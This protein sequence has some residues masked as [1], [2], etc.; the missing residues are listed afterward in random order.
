MLQ[1]KSQT[2]NSNMIGRISFKP[3]DPPWMPPGQFSQPLIGLH[4]FGDWTLNVGWAMHENCYKLSNLSCQQPP[5]GNWILRIFGVVN[6]N[7][8]YAY[9]AW[10]LIAILLYIKLI[11]KLSSDFTVLQKIV[12]FF[13]IV[14][15]SSGN[16]ISLDRGSLHFMAFALL[17]MAILNYEDDKKLNSLIYLTLA[18]SLKPQLLLATIYLLKN[19]QI[20]PFLYSISVPIASNLILMLTFPGQYFSNLHGYLLASNGYVSSREAF[21]N[22]MNSVSIVGII[23]RVVEF[24]QG[25]DTSD[26]LSKFS[27]KLFVPGLLYLIIIVLVILSQR[28]SDRTK[29]VCALSTISLVVPSS[30]GYLLGW[31]TTLI[32]AL[33]YTKNLL[34]F[35]KY[36]VDKLL[37]MALILI[38]S[39]PGF[40]IVDDVPGFSRHVGFI[41][42]LPVILLALVISELVFNIRENIQN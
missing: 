14:I 15:F 2:G 33:I 13:F 20:R 4:H 7:Y 34:L 3:D 18:V 9:I 10:T 24:L 5:V 38:I 39:T 21:G 37:F 25:W 40:I 29:L 31:S 19:R 27:T 32:F 28:I 17:G 12:L 35:E 22:I 26:L 36:R 23:S 16:I 11:K 6:T 41:F 1:Y 30:G 8:G 42:L